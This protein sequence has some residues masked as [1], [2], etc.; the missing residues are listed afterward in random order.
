LEKTYRLI[1]R[2]QPATLI[3]NNRHIKPFPGEDFQTWEKEWPGHAT[4][5]WNIHQPIAD[6]PQ[7]TC[8]SINDSW[9]YTQSDRHFKS[10]AELI[11]LLVRY[12]GYD[13][14][15]LLNVG[16]LPNRKFPSE[17]IERLK[18]VGAWLGENG[19]SIYGTRS[20]PITPRSW[21]VTVRRDS[22]IY[23]HILDWQEAVLPLPKLS[24]RI[25]SAR[26]LGNG[27]K[28]EVVEA[29]YGSLL[30]LPPSANDPVNNIVVLKT[31]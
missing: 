16:P 27:D 3:G 1:H 25:K 23:V 9:G 18:A 19:E 20:G 11:Q 26:M 7:E 12:A 21:G 5:E 22:T 10:P 31:E 30:K 28:L 17:S 15:F 8:N 2:L 24:E 13:S 4:Q 6:L 14:N 29:D